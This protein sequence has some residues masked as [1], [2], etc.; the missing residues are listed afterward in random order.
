VFSCQVIHYEEGD[1]PQSNA[2]FQSEAAIL[3]NYG[4]QLGNMTESAKLQY[5]I[6]PGQISY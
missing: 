6:K 5:Q 1:E 3:I 4:L 2:E